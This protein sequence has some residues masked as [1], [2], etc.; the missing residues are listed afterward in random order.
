MLT[1]ALEA[2]GLVA[3][4]RAVEA[5]SAALDIESGRVFERLA[6]L[7]AE[8]LVHPDYVD[9]IRRDYEPDILSP[10]AVGV[11]THEEGIRGS[12][13]YIVSSLRDI[14]SAI[15]W[16]ERTLGEFH[17]IVP[18]WPEFNLPPI[19]RYRQVVLSASPK[20]AGNAYECRME[21]KRLLPDCLHKWLTWARKTNRRPKYE[22]LEVLATCNLDRSVSRREVVTWMKDQANWPDWYAGH[23]KAELVTLGCEIMPDGYWGRLLNKQGRSDVIRGNRILPPDV[24]V[25]IRVYIDPMDF[26]RAATG[27]I[28]STKVADLVIHQLE[29]GLC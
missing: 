6:K 26:W 23:T 13:S 2:H 7:W 16:G 9:W 15:D 8:W 24:L 22:L 27:R 11:F 19:A 5:I 21:L 10:F 25:Q 29:L 14:I 28:K 18:I 3:V 17:D 20:G 1:L 4:C 12:E